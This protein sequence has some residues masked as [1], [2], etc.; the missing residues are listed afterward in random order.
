MN[1]FLGIGI[2]GF[3]A[4]ILVVVIVVA[5]IV[6]LVIRSW[7]K[8]ARAD[9]ALVISGK[10]QRNEDGSTSATTVVVNGRAIVNP[11]TQRHE[12]ISL[13]QRQVN[14]RADAQSADNVTV[15][16]D[17][18]ALVKIGSDS[19]LVRRAAERFASQDEA[20]ESFTQDQLEGVL[21]GVIAQQTVISLMRDRKV[22][23]EQI[24]ETVI[25]ELREQGLILDSF[26]IRGIADDVG[27]IQS[28]GAPEIEAKRQAAEISQT[29]AERAVAK[30]SIR[31]QEQNLVEQQALDTNKANAQSEV[32]RARA[33]AEQAEALAG[34]KARQ[35]VLQQQ[36]ENK[37]AQLDAD[38]K[39]VADA[40][41]YRRQKDAEA[42]AY[43]ERRQ[44]EARAEVA[45]ADARAVKL[46]AEAD[47]EAERLAGEARAAAMRAEAEA[48]RENQEALLAQRVVD[49]LPTLM[50]TFAK[51]YAQIGEITVVS[52]DGNDG[53]VAGKQFSGESA[54]AL[55][56]VFDTVQA[57][58]G[59]SIPDL[60]QGRATGTA[61][62]EAIGEAL[63]EQSAG[64][65]TG[66]APRDGATP[67]PAGD[68]PSAPNR[69]ADE[70]GTD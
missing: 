53:D 60:I 48:L 13:R 64:R 32:G 23:S 7:I 61:Q 16:V 22:F 5:L 43:E 21:R 4:L 30:E 1:T 11:V 24:A 39:R 55:R 26:Q 45:D 44:A 29:N 17:A 14:M 37:Q 19:A 65:P 68:A 9:E 10:S 18:V 51:G 56:G 20:I 62:G 54:G 42:D 8:V 63:R 67:A 52:S 69:G 59:L 15:S 38:V 3:I 35:D 27:Y 36:A 34:E 49:Q 40:E 33:Q 57:T 70:D 31:N 2:V 46:R 41:L 50:E 6:F 12:V 58:L 28:L 66:G 25:P 47:A